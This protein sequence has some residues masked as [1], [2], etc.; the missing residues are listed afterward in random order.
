VS[1]LQVWKLEGA[2]GGGVKVKGGEI[3]SES[4][5]TWYQYSL[6]HLSLGLKLV[7]LGWPN[8]CRDSGKEGSC[9]AQHRLKNVALCNEGISIVTAGK[10]NGQL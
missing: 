4:R 2:F 8:Y 10:L 6:S 5:S 1:S 3:F 9:K 7:L